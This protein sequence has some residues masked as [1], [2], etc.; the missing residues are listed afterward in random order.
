LAAIWPAVDVAAKDERES[1]AIIKITVLTKSR[2]LRF[3][4][5]I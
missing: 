3:F 5:V 4:I 2:G 1:T